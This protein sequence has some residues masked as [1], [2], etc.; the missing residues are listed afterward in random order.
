LASFADSAATPPAPLTVDELLAVTRERSHAPLRLRERVVRWATAAIVLG[1]SLALV[2]LGPAGRDGSLYAFVLAA[3]AFAIAYSIDV[4]TVVGSVTPTTVVFVPI[5]FC[6]PARTVPLVVCAACCLAQLVTCARTGDP[7]EKVVVAA[8]NAW[9]AL[10]PALVVVCFHEPAATELSAWAVVCVALGAQLGSDIVRILGCEWLAL[11]VSPR[12]LAGPI[13][14]VCL[15][16][17]LLAPVGLLI[18][19]A[20]GVTDAALLLPLPLLVLV[21]LYARERSKRFDHE[22]ELSDAYRGTAF[23]LGDVV[24]AD[25]SY[26]GKHSRQVVALVLAVCERLGLDSETLRLAELTALLHDVG[27]LRVPPEIINKPGPLSAGELELVRSHTLEGERLLVPIGGLLADV[28]RLVR[29]CHERFDGGGYPDGLAG[30]AI[31]LVARIVACCD[32]WDAMRSDRPYRSA[33]PLPVALA[34]LEAER[35]HQFDPAVVD[36]LVAVLDARVPQPYA[37]AA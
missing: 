11:R 6:L 20:A 12:L 14:Q 36:A 9:F 13:A 22:L 19:V 15:I 18:A 28:G 29:S 8:G 35:G 32:A 37:L 24:E 3:A 7:L 2:T 31:P 34:E 21:A 27:K 16:D 33:L 26:T 23:L 30:A 5:L 17:V 4:E 25:D 10:A 1:A